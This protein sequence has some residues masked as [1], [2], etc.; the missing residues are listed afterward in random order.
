M[1]IDAILICHRWK[2]LTAFL[3]LVTAGVSTSA[4]VHALLGTLQSVPVFF[5]ARQVPTRRLRARQREIASTTGVAATAASLQQTEL[6][7]N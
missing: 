7:V 5:L 1:K 2:H 4:L 3:K 6:H